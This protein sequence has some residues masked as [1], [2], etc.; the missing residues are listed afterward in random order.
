VREKPSV[1]EAGLLLQ[2]AD[3]GAI[4]RE[5]LFDEVP[6]VPVR[7]RLRP[8]CAFGSDLQPHLGG[9]PLLGYTIANI[10]DSEDIGPH[11]Y[12]SGYVHVPRGGVSHYSFNR[13][14]NGLVYTCRGGFIDTAHVRD[15]IDWALYVSNQVGRA[16]LSGE[17]HEF[18]LPDEGGTR[19]II[20]NKLDPDLVRRI[21]ARRL[22]LWLAE[23]ITWK[24]SLW[25]EIS[26]WY[27]FA[28]VPGFT[29]QGSAFSPE[30]LYSN[31]LGVRLLPAIIYHHAERSELDYN[32]S[33]DEWLRQV[34]A[35]LQP[36]PRGVAVDAAEAVDKLWWDSDA[37]TPSKEQVLR[38]T[39]NFQEVIEPWLV[40]VS[41][42]PAALREACG[43]APE[44]QNLNVPEE[45]GGV[46][47]GKWVTLEIVLSDELASQAPFTAI[48]R[49][50]T[51]ADFPRIVE[52]IR[53]QNRAEF[54]DRADRP[55]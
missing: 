27:G 55:D 29:E 22:T 2:Q 7:E 19:R 50:V 31:A 43:D 21:G 5:Y 24:M 34:I 48:G 51:Q 52:E 10:I 8:C 30:D 9:V 53:K 41:R 15:Y 13:E 17:R 42:M 11:S 35:Y 18:A 38:R 20:V 37:L 26:T 39:M 45:H 6:A 46:D 47:V 28:T 36:V 40:P 16:L 12:D 14:N 23:W 49:T 25:H 1:A 32:S 3:P 44:A 33:V 4:E 54:G